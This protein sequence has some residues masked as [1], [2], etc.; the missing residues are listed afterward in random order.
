M[1]HFLAAMLHVWQSSW[2]KHRKIFT[3]AG[4]FAAAAAAM[5]PPD[6]QLDLLPSCWTPTVHLLALFE[7][8]PNQRPSQRNKRFFGDQTNAGWPSAHLLYA[9]APMLCQPRRDHT[10]LWGTKALTRNEAWA[11]SLERSKITTETIVAAHQSITISQTT[12]SWKS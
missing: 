10:K 8:R 6:H 9:W 2:C 7:G 4:L 5:L 1:C 3:R 12:H 11:A